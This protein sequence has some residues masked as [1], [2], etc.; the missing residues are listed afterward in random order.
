MFP[1]LGLTPRKRERFRRVAAL[2]L[3]ALQGAVALSPMV[4]P[5][6]A[7]RPQ[8]HVEERG[9]VHPYAHDEAKCALC[10]ARSM[11]AAVP[12]RS[13][14]IPASTGQQGAQLLVSLSAPTPDAGPTN[15]SRAPPLTD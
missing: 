14:S 9:A 11:H 12:A 3:F 15:L 7:N 1:A 4:D 6:Q 2:A 13:Y 10:A 8:T 5:V